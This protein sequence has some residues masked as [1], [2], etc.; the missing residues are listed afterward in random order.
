MAHRT[1]RQHAAR[2][3]LPEGFSVL[4]PSDAADVMDVVRDDGEESAE[5][6]S[7]PA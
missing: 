4:D 7:V 6:A 3:G 1:L 2:L 5:R